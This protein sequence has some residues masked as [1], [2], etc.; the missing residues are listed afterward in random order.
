MSTNIG[1]HIGYADD[2]TNWITTVN[3]SETCE[4]MGR[5]L[6][7]MSVWCKRWRATINVPKTDYIVHSHQ[8]HQQ[9]A[10]YMGNPP[11]VQV[12]VKKCLG[13]ILDEAFTF[14]PHIDHIVT[15]ALSTLNKLGTI[16]WSFCASDD[17]L[18]SMCM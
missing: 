8:G 15:I 6:A 11:L 14:K 5:N 2:L 7:K 1:Q 4:E 3:L 12:D 13:V 17:I 9:V 18:I 10:V 16:S